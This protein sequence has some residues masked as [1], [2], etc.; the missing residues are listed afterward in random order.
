MS[1]TT[2]PAAPAHLRPGI[3]APRADPAAQQPQAVVLAASP[4][5]EA[6]V[7]VA[8]RTARPPPPS[9]SAPPPAVCCGGGANA[10]AIFTGSSSCLRKDRGWRS[11][12]RLAA[13]TSE[14]SY[15]HG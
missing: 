11:L 5:V 1:S 7:A 4:G 10:N 6:S 9:L 3:A 13:P 8:R 15:R 2:S 12:R 14:S